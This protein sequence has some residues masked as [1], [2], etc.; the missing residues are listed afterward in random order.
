VQ[1]SSRATPI[2]RLHGRLIMYAV[3]VTSSNATFSVISLMSR[4]PGPLS[5]SSSRAIN[6]TD[7][8]SQ[9]CCADPFQ[10]D[11]RVK[12]RFAR[13]FP[14]CCCT[15]QLVHYELT[16]VDD[17]I[18]LLGWR[19][20]D[21]QR[22]PPPFGVSPTIECFE[23]N[24]STISDLHNKLIVRREFARADGVANSMSGRVLGALLANARSMAHVPALAQMLCLIE[25][26][27]GVTYDV[28]VLWAVRSPHYRSETRA[29]FERQPTDLN[30][31]S[32][33][34]EETCRYPFHF[35][36]TGDVLGEI[37]KFVTAETTESV[38]ASRSATESSRHFNQHVVTHEMT[39]G[40]VDQFEIVEVN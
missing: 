18:T 37:Q 13:A 14:R 24:N 10:P 40:V 38:R 3:S 6:V 9:D 29:L 25:R 20:E 26:N 11:V 4:L 5:L 16:Y 21:V 31:P 28:N 33:N 19:D 30:R 17:E 32:N 27:V 1:G 12:V 35:D 34:F 23:S 8:G 15:Y 2:P 39:V 22:N 7:P 36:F